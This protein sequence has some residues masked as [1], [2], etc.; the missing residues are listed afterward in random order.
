LLLS[1]IK[2]TRRSIQK[3]FILD[4]VVQKVDIG[5]KKMLQSVEMSSG[6]LPLSLG[7]RYGKIQA[8]GIKEGEMVI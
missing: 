2:N 3:R 7:G 6:Y 5:S 1:I 8:N 4:E